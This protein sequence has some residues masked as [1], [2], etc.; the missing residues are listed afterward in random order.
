[1][2]CAGLLST[3]NTEPGADPIV[4]E[5]YFAAAPARVFQAWTDPDIVMRWFGRV[6]NSLHSAT[7]D[8]RRGGAWRFVESSDD[9]KSV[10][11][12]GEYVADPLAGCRKALHGT[13][14]C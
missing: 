2:R 11:F 9:V 6:P 1:M 5:G 10:G 7:I 3:G 4:V 14:R 8:L 12:E 13:L